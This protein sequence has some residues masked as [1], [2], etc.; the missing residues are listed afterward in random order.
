MNI[1]FFSHPTYEPW[2]W[3][4]PESTGIGGSE[5]SHIELA[6]RLAARGHHVTSYAPL[7]FVGEQ[8]HAGVR[9]V[10]CNNTDW[11]DA[12]ALWI[13]YRCP[14]ALDLIPP[15]VPAWLICQDVDYPTL[16]AARAARATRIVALCDEHAKYLRKTHPDAD[17][18]ICVSSNGIKPELIDGTLFNTR[19]ASPVL[20]N[21][22]R[23][24]YASSPDRGL[25][26]L[27]YIF[28]RVREIIPDAE[29]HVFYGF[30]NLDKMLARDPSLS[31]ADDVREIQRLMQQPGVHHHGRIPQPQ[32]A[33]EWL[34]SGIWC[35]PTM[36]PET[37]CIT[38]MDAQAL[39]AIPVVNPIWALK[40][41]VQA[42]VAID[43]DP[44]R[45]LLVRGWYVDQV[46]RLMQEPETQADIRREMMPWA[47][48]RFSWERVADEW[49]AW[50]RTD[51]MRKMREQESASVPCMLESYCVLEHFYA[52]GIAEQ[53]SAS[54]TPEVA[55]HA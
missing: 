4:S 54:A 22:R 37:S 14:E 45:D 52:R 50:A 1:N 31:C 11:S 55:Q 17:D 32:L 40:D 33:E 51:Y 38:S 29:L 24:M 39:G 44:Y 25:L 43:G 49:S 20:R 3:E 28:S 5:T 46:A 9:W 7:P 48:E 8:D 41:N 19:H 34:K 36:W 18:R 6:T 47:R 15:D 16:T 27:L 23:M 30:Q 26:V 42:G 21:P 13:I 53:E 2:S 10:S 12:S 35:Y